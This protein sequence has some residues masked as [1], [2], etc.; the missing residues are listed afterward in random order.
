MVDD[1]VCQEFG[2]KIHRSCCWEALLKYVSK[3]V[4]GGKKLDLKTAGGNKVPNRMIVHFNVLCSCFSHEILEQ[5]PYKWHSY[6]HNTRERA[7][8]RHTQDMKSVR[9]PQKF[10]GCN[11]CFVLC[12]WP[13]TRDP[14]SPIAA[15]DELGPKKMQHVVVDWWMEGEPAQCIKIA[16]Q[17]NKASCFKWNTDLGYPSNTGGYV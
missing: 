5:Q 15:R 2:L 13:W 9:K 6:Y 12:F 14:W 10:R 7:A 1:S 8:D 3:S 11:W 17:R 4:L 16:N